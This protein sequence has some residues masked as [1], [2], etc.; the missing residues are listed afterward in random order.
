MIG[1]IYIFAFIVYALL[2]VLVSVYASRKA[3]QRGIA[4]WKWGA[5]AAFLMYL[6]VFWDHIP[7]L[8]AHKYYCKKEAGF[9]V[10]KTLEEWQ[11]ENPGAAET[12]TYK[13]ISDSEGDRNRY[14]RHLNQ[15]FDSAFM[16]TPIFLSVKQLRHKIIDISNNEVIAEYVDYSS[17]GSFQNANTL[18]DYKLW[19]AGNSCEIDRE[20]RT[21]FNKFRRKA[22][23]IGDK[24]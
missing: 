5:P 16:R 11:K 23:K 22:K 3:R 20:S 12:L 24:L 17:G 18:T 1:L 7:T 4:G 21:L 15:R 10:Y 19:L 6:I 8:V 2:T 9:K 14:V 13:E